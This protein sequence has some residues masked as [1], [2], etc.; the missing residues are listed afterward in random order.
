MPFGQS[1]ANADG[2]L[3]G[4]KI[5]ETEHIVLKIFQ[6]YFWDLGD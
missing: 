2:P 3:R 4:H 5:V 1:A 6:Y